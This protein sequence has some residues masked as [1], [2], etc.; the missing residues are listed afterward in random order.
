MD[1][2]NGNLPR[3]WDMQS[4]G[5]ATYGMAHRLVTLDVLAPE[6]NS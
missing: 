4:M 3:V 6:V 2:G 1:V 5:G